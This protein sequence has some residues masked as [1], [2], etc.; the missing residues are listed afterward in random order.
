MEIARL[1][2]D[3]LI[4]NV[5][6][7]WDD[8]SDSVRDRVRLESLLEQVGMAPEDFLAELVRAGHRCGVA[9]AAI[10]QGLGLPLVVEATVNKALKGD[11]HREK[12]LIYQSSGMLPSPRNSFTAIRGQN[13]QVNQ[14]PAAPG[15]PTM[16]EENAVDVMGRAR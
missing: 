16:E 5:L 9:Q 2:G 11:G 12:R 4:R 8:I 15:L 6:A 7:I 3:K 10:V 13:I 1:S 14:Q